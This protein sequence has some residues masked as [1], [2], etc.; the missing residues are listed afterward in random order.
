MPLLVLILFALAATFQQQCKCKPEDQFNNSNAEPE[1][2][3]VKIEPCQFADEFYAPCW[4][5]P[6]HIDANVTIEV[7]TGS[8]NAN[9]SPQFTPDP[10][11]YDEI[12]E[13]RDDMSCS[14]SNPNNKFTLKVPKTGAYALVITIRS[15]TC[16]YCCW[17]TGDTQCGNPPPVPV[18]GSSQYDYTAGKP[19]WVVEQIFV[20]GSNRPVA[21]DGSNTAKWSPD[22]SFYIVRKCSN[23]GGCTV[24]R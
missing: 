1:F 18:P 20:A 2:L 10:N 8:Y 13:D 17:G 24:R 11:P 15:K 5:T 6:G 9:A 3:E 7:R 19:K 16:S 21:I 12:D 23:C 14:I 4:E 22:P